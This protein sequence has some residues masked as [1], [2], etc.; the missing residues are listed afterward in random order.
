MPSRMAPICLAC[1]NGCLKV[2]GGLFGGPACLI[3]KAADVPGHADNLNDGHLFLVVVH[4]LVAGGGVL[5]S[6]L[7]V[8]DLLVVVH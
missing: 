8:R 5:D 4:H 1:A 7:L 6:I 3:L 2:L